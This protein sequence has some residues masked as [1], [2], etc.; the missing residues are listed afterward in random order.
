MFE[1]IDENCTSV[2]F[3]NLSSDA[4]RLIIAAINR[5]ISVYI[6]YD[7]VFDLLFGFIYTTAME[8]A[9]SLEKLTNEKLLNLHAVSHPVMLSFLYLC[10]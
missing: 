7:A 3:L 1:V 8:L 10:N 4:L 6:I 2:L 5:F 9:L